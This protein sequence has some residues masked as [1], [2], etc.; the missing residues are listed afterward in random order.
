[1]QSQEYRVLSNEAG[2]QVEL[3]IMNLWI[4]PLDEYCNEIFVKVVISPFRPVKALSV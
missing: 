2:M 4:V 1:M 3:A